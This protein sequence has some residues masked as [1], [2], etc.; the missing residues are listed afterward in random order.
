M[1]SEEVPSKR[2]SVQDQVAGEDPLMFVNR[3]V[4][5]G[6]APLLKQHE[7]LLSE[8]PT[9]CHFTRNPT[10]NRFQNV[11]LFDSTRVILKPMSKETGD[12]IHASWYFAVAVAVAVTVSFS[13][14]I[15]CRFLLGSTTNSTY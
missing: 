8:A 7:Q 13:D 6:K 10:K 15:N 9:I 1:A 11:V 2:E 5:G 14:P 4:K 12:Y 3:T